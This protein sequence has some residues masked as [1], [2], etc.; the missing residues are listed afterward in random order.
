MKH[1]RMSPQAKG[2]R[3]V[4]AIAIGEAMHFSKEEPHRI[5]WVVCIPCQGCKRNILTFAIFSDDVVDR[6]QLKHVLATVMN[7]EVL[8]RGNS[9]H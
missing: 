8:M 5:F 7:G 1:P 9:R 6:K 2:L 3:L 4:T